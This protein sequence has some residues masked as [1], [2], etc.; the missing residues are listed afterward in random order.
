MFAWGPSPSRQGGTPVRPSRPDNTGGTPVHPG[1]AKTARASFASPTAS[2]RSPPGRRGT[3]VTSWHL[4][5]CREVSK[6]R[7]DPNG[8][9]LSRPTIVPWYAEEG[10]VRGF[11]DRGWPPSRSGKEWPHSQGASRGEPRPSLCR[12]RSPL[13][14]AVIL[15]RFA[16]PA[17]EWA[18]SQTGLKLAPFR[19][20]PAG[21]ASPGDGQRLKRV[22]MP[23][24]A[25]TRG[26]NQAQ[27]G[28]PREKHAQGG[29]H[30][31][32]RQ[33]GTNAEMDA[34]AEAD[35]LIRCA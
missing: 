35:M 30:L 25:I 18:A 4:T 20:D 21:D 29:L 12:G 15:H 10:F 34:G 28:Q 3:R 27:V 17:K 24:V 2:A 7:C 11:L 19:C 5:L 33:W 31:E 1:K 8:A 16:P 23:R 22:E 13:W 14:S 6:P 9:N 26:A 32:T